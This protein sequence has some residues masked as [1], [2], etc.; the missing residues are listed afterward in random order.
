[1]ILYYGKR[2]EGKRKEQ[3]KNGAKERGRKGGRGRERGFY[4]HK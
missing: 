1:M 2:T 3:E 4:I